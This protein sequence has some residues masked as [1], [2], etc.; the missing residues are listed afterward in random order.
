MKIEPREFGEHVYYLPGYSGEIYKTE[1][2]VYFYGG[3][4]DEYP[5]EYMR[6]I[7]AKM[8]ELASEDSS[9]S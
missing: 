7:L 6:A 9:N 3:Y 8:E 4:S 2:N 1:H 5:I